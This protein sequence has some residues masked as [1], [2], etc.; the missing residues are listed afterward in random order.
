[1]D[2]ETEGGYAQYLGRY[3]AVFTPVAAVGGFVSDVI[4]PLAPLST[5][6]FWLSLV[7]SIVLVGLLVFVKAS[8]PRCLPLLILTGS[9]FVFSGI[10]LA[11]QTKESEAQG[12]LA[13][14]IPLIAE[15]Q[16]TLG[17]VRQDVAEIKV[18]TARTEEA[19]GRVEGSTRRTEAATQS[20]VQSTERMAISLEAIQQGFAGLAKSGGV[21]DNASRPEEHYH[22]AR[23]Y[24][25]RGDYGNARRSYNAFFASRLDLLDPHLRYQSFLKVQEGRAGAREV[26]AALAEQDKRPLM[27]FVQLL[28]QDAP[29][30]IE[31]L[32]TFLAANPD[33]APGHYELSRDYSAARKGTQSLG[34]KQAE[35]AALERFKAL[36]GEGKFLRW[37]L[38]QSLAVE[39]LDDAEARLTS[40]AVLKQSAD[41]PV[42]LSAMR[43]NADWM[44][45]LQMKEMP[46][47]VFYRL[48]GEESF[49]STGLTEATDPTTGLKMPNLFLSLKAST[50]PSKIA[51][52]YTDVGGEMRG[53]FLL[54]FN[55]EMALVAAQKK[56]LDMTKNSWVAF[57]DYDGKVLLYF[58]SLVSNRCAISAVS[59]GIDT[60]ATPSDFAL[61]PCNAKDPYNVGDGLL[62]ITVPGNSK[63]ASVR[64]SFKDGTQSETVR[65]ER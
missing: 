39:W 22:N 60:S 37:F 55:P 56:I 45:T 50:G 61:S 47:E 10:L 16:Q 51:V 31:A 54:D 6:V 36:H 8:R 21:I 5:Y 58:T 42:S 30:R 34:D 41:A 19:V 15:I 2:E 33:F 35:L 64:L 11:F 26:Y 18:T 59:Y 40:L 23:L 52:K 13:T 9:F 1:M 14:H 65:I 46:R 20:I 7:V 38:D 27:A 49:R 32:K 25:Q 53:P 63:F 3:A 29:Q 44:V 24:E 28:L 62:Y 57:R 17:L 4:Q 12:V 43:S 48:D